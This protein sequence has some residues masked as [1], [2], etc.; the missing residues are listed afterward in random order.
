MLSIL[1]FVH[2]MLM[3]FSIIIIDINLSHIL[4]NLIFG[5]LVAYLLSPGTISR[6]LLFQRVCELGR[7]RRLYHVWIWCFSFWLVSTS[8]LAGAFVGPFA[9]CATVVARELLI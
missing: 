8:C 6:W 4:Q 5:S 7:H 3:G 2:I 1:Q 9:G